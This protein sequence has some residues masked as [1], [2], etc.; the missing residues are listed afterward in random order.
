MVNFLYFI[1][2]H[3]F[4]L[5]SKPNTQ[6]LSVLKSNKVSVSIYETLSMLTLGTKFEG[7]NLSEH[8]T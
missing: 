8:T 5:I 1:I 2:T 4:L 3:I 6:N 7:Q